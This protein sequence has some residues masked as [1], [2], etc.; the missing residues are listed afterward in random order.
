MAV[1]KKNSGTH[2]KNQT[3]SKKSPPASEQ[4]SEYR[5]ARR[6][7]KMQKS[8]KLLKE[9]LSSRQHLSFVAPSDYSKNQAFIN[10][11]LSWLQFDLRV[12]LEAR[13]KNN[14]L[15]ERLSFLAITANNLDEF[16]MVRVASLKDMYNA[17]YEGLDIAG[18]TASEQLNAISE[19]THALMSLM[20]STYSRAILPALKKSGINILKA[21]QLNE[22]QKSELREYFE[23]VIYPILTPMAVDSG[24]P[25]P[26]INNKSLNICAL[27]ER[28][29]DEDESKFV[30]IQVPGVIPRLYRFKTQETE[31]MDQLAAE[32]LDAQ[33]TADSDAND[34]AEPESYKYSFF[35]LE[36]IIRLFL[37]E[38]FPGMSIL[39]EGVYRIL[40]NADLEIDDED[41]ADLLIE[42]EKQIRL[43]RWGEVIRLEAESDMDYRLLSRLLPNLKVDE[44]D[45]Y[46]I[47]GP[48]DLTLLSKLRGDHELKQHGEWYYPPYT[49]QLPHQLEERRL[50]LLEK[51]NEEPSIF[52]L[53]KEGSMLMHHPYDSFDPVLQFIKEAATD[54]QV[55]AIKQ[56]LYRISGD[57]PI[58]SYMEEAAKNGKQV[59]VLVELKARFDEENNIHWA[60]RLETAGCHVIYGL[61]G[62]KT[63]S[64]IT[65]VV[66][67]END[68]IRRYL[69][70]GTGNYND[71]TAKLYTDMG[72]FV[73]NSEVGED[74]TEFFNMLSGFAEPNYWNALVA[75][76]LWLR[77]TFEKL[78]E[79]EM[80]QVKEGG[81]GHIRAKM[82]SLV[83]EGMIKLLYKASQAGVEIDLIVRGICCLRPGVSGLSDNIRVRSLVGRYLEHARI[84]WFYNGGKKEIYLASADWMTRNLDR[85]VELMFPI[86]EEDCAALV[87]EVLDIQEEDTNRSHLMQPDGTYKKPDRRGK[88]ALD[89]QLRSCEL[90]VER[91][92]K[93]AD[94]METRVFVPAAA[95]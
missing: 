18:L 51:G 28:R 7:K 74:G 16:F 48:L 6:E 29:D 12:L 61:V 55:L 41:A 45:V 64:K 40:R 39:A 75:A 81:K 92:P 44:E 87:E 91:A 83:D 15:M 19:Q 17:D 47:D 77:S 22:G 80:T 14:P 73:S 38:L 23:E 70:L 3:Q 2:A 86:F 59:L 78:I 60:R 35:L 42:I 32:A 21:E 72:Y 93:P 65:L 26:L 36:D 54:P 8:R 20:Y 58:I 79:R 37:P 46:L 34:E 13:D 5:D 66:R 50:S 11:E 67:R 52:D 53:I 10:R 82:N 90:A 27:L 57:S 76:P 94:V 43:R 25:F 33:A 88:Q 62:L 1:S 68:G 89:A 49:P 24:R 85:R 4:G 30:T 31:T 71:Q 84:F 69:H 56:T 63:H 95:Q 9:R